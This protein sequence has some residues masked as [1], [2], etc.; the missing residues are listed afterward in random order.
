MN[1]YTLKNKNYKIEH[2]FENYVEKCY[3][4]F[5]SLKIKEG[6]IYER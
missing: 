4:Q 1:R 2:L 6:E 3:N 5:K